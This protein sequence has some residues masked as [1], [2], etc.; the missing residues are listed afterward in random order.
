MKVRAVG[1]QVLVQVDF[2]MIDEMQKK[3]VLELPKDFMQRMKGGCQVATVLHVGESAFDD[4]PPEVRATIVAGRKVI[5]GRY[6]GHEVD[7]HPEDRDDDAI[8][9][10]MIS[11]KEVRG[12]IALEG[13]DGADV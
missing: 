12:I 2:D 6:P 1:Q 13:E 7:L 4:E 3:T 5:T 8:R 10:R 11:D 9:L